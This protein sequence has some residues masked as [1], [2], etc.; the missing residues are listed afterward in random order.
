MQAEMSHH[1]MVRDSH[2]VF[3]DY[4]QALHARDAAQADL[5]AVS[6]DT[7]HNSGKIQHFGRLYDMAEEHLVQ[8]M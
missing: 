4:D 2:Q 1:Q 8:V 3:Q 7:V 5:Q 6:A